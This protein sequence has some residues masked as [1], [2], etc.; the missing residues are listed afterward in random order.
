MVV[1]IRN[2]SFVTDQ[3]IAVDNAPPPPAPPRRAPVSGG[4]LNGSALALP[5]PVYPDG[6]RRMRVEGTVEVEVVIDENGKVVSAK[7][8]S[9]PVALRDSAVQA[10][11]RARFTPSKLSGQAVQ[12]SGRI[13]YNFKM[14]R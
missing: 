3:P 2:A 4:V 11:Q 13:I 10:A 9:G 8:I 7:A 5:T 1:D 6:A 14:A 12:V